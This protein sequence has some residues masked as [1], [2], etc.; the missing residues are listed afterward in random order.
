MSGKDRLIHFI[1]ENEDIYEIPTPNSSHWAADLHTGSIIA[2]QLKKDEDI[3]AAAS[4]FIDTDHEIHERAYVDP[5]RTSSSID[6]PGQS[7]IL[8]GAEMSRNKTGRRACLDAS[9]YFAIELNPVCNEASHTQQWWWDPNSRV[10]RNAGRDLC[11]AVL[12]DGTSH[13]RVGHFQC[14]E[15]DIMMRW[16]VDLGGGAGQRLLSSYNAKKVVRYI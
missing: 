6:H 4:F 15:G 14:N 11:L 8:I 7:R 16:D 12:R 9:Y 3:Q 13:D 10:I 5:Q 2:H 1:T